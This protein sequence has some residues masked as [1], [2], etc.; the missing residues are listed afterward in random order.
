MCIFLYNYSLVR[1]PTFCLCVR[2][3]TICLCVRC[4]TICLCV[5]C[6]TSCLCVRCQ[7]ICLCVRCP[8]VCLCVRCPTI[9]LC[10]RC[11][12]ICQS[13][14]RDECLNEICWQFPSH[15]L[16]TKTIFGS[17]KRNEEGGSG[18][19]SRREGGGGLTR[20]LREGDC[21]QENQLSKGVPQGP[22][23]KINI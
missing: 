15:H 14:C 10:V 21:L 16:D 20:F 13:D 8:T 23:R 18:Q 7:T 4:P 17:T 12:S 5:R 6:P 19:C 11:L 2:C 3:P 22:R 1:C 9:C